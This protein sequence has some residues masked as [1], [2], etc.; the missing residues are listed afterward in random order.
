MTY[1]ED[2]PYADPEKAALRLMEHANAVEPVQD[3]RI[4]I[5][6]INRPFLF[7][8]MARPTEYIAGMKLAIERGW[9]WMHESGTYLK[10]TP[11]GCRA[12]RLGDR[13]RK[14]PDRSRAMR[15]RDAT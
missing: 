14:I 8:D 10:L 4:H 11:A 13:M 3:G 6:K 9:L 2:S 5:H 1:V 12:V 7:E 15:N